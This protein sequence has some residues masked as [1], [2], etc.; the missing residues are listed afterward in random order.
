MPIDI[1]GKELHT[2]SEAKAYLEIS[3]KELVP[4]LRGQVLE[5]GCG[6]G[7]LT[8]FLAMEFPITAVDIDEGFLKEARLG[9]DQV[10]KVQGRSAKV[11]QF[12]TW[13]LNQPPKPEW[14]NHFDSLLSCQV[15]EH[16]EDDRDILRRYLECVK[17]GGRV[18]LQLPS[19]AFAYSPLDK[20]LGHVRRYDKASVQ[21]LFDEMGLKTVSIYYYN[22]VGLLGW[23]WAKLRRRE[24]LPKG[25]LKLFNG[26]VKAALVPDLLMKHIAGLNVIGVAEK[27]H[28]H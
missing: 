16:L 19:H 28:A 2:L 8:Q 24:A 20:S 22:F 1:S 3:A 25:E 10:A 26:L 17:P 6:N 4:H 15:L 7:N 13:D 18:V 14:Q 11:S 21:K 5:L 9:L 27:P 23:L 12:L